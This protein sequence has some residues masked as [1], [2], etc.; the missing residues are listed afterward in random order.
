MIAVDFKQV[1]NGYY[2]KKEVDKFVQGILLTY[3]IVY[4]DYYIMC[5]KYK[6]LYQ[7]YRKLERRLPAC[8]KTT[9]FFNSSAKKIS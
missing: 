6:E 2:D 8:K 5:N 3:N 4:T 7:N 9:K 1:E